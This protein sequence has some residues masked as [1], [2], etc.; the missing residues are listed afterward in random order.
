MADDD[1]SVRRERALWAAGAIALAGLLAAIRLAL[2]L[3]GTI[4]VRVDPLVKSDAI[5]VL[6]SQRIDRT[7]EAATLYQE[8]WSRR[9]ILLRPADLY[10]R[11]VLAELGITVPLFFDEQRSALQQM[12]VPSEAIIELRE[13]CEESTRGEAG[14]VAEFV[15]RRQW[16]RIIIVT[17]TF[18]TRR[19]RRYFAH[20]ARG[21]YAIIARRSRYDDA[22]PERWWQN[23]YSRVDVFFEYAKFPK[24]LLYLLH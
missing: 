3:A 15:S 5:V 1:R 14:L 2:P 24:S 11:G 19:A 8:G 23:P 20:A 13:R 21:R 9:I 18:H 6:A 12:G 16:S 7:L 4:L 10:T 22:V 17:S